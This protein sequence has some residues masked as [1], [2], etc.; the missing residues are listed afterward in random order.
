MDEHRRRAA[1]SILFS[2]S[3][4]DW[5]VENYI[6]EALGD[7]YIITPTANGRYGWLTIDD[8]RLEEDCINLLLELGVRV[9]P[10]Q[11]RWSADADRVKTDSGDST[12]AN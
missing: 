11:P 1:H 7:S 3:S 6:L 8:E 5:T 12:E 4:A 10:L 9:R 2:G